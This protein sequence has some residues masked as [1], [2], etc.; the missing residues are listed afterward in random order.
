M[1]IE[2]PSKSYYSFTKTL[3][4]NTSQ[5]TRIL[6]NS[7]GGEMILRRADLLLF[8]QSIIDA[9]SV[10][11]KIALTLVHEPAGASAGS[12]TAYGIYSGSG[13]LLISNVYD[14][15]VQI[16]TATYLYPYELTFSSGNDYILENGDE[17]FLYT[18]N[19]PGTASAT[20]CELRGTASFQTSTLT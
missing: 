8:F 11:A 12:I 3:T 15:S 5:R 10:S 20:S 17:L 18:R 9:T 4:D 13:S 6:L 16:K 19:T 2:T 1:S 7:S 14:T